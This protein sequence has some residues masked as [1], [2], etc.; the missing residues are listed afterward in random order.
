[1][2]KIESYRII[3]TDDYTT[4]IGRARHRH[5][6]DVEVAREVGAVEGLPARIR[7]RCEIPPC[8]EI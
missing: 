6:G 1:M 8:Y 5:G 2:N 3:V 4:Y 7:T